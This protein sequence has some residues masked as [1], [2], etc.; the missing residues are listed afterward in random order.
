[1][2]EAKLPDNVSPALARFADVLCI[3]KLEIFGPQLRNLLAGARDPQSFRRSRRAPYG[4][5]HRPAS[6]VTRRAQKPSTVAKP[7]HSAQWR[8]NVRHAP[9]LHSF[10]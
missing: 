6:G 9:R 10:E 3:Y 5:T 4:L 7:R 1:M 8:I 2:S